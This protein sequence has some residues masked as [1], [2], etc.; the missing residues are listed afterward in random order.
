MSRAGADRR[1][2]V[3]VATITS[4][5]LPGLSLRCRGRRPS[6]R[7]LFTPAWALNASVPRITDLVHLGL[8]ALRRVRSDAAAAD[9]VTGEPPREH[10]LDRRGLVYLEAE[11]GPD[12]NLRRALMFA[13]LLPSTHRR[14]DWRIWL[15]D[16]ATGL[17]GWVAGVVT[18][19]SALRLVPSAFVTTTCA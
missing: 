8:C 16:G 19:R 3:L 17:R 4:V 5:Y 15:S 7:T 12:G 9:R 10:E 2:A 11:R 6:N 13:R 18:T 1:P 14:A